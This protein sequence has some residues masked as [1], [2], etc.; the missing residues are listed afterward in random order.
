MRSGKEGHMDTP[1][2]ETRAKGTAITVE[3]LGPARYAEAAAMLGRAFDTDPLWQYLF[4]DP[5]KRPD[6]IAWLFERTMRVIAPL[7]ASYVT[8]GGEG[9]ALWVPPGHGPEIDLWA[10]LRAGFAW[11]PFHIGFE[12]LHRLWQVEMDILRRQR[13][14][15][16]E[17][18]WILS[19]I[20][21]DPAFRRQDVGS[22]LLNH[23]LTRIDQGHGACHVITHNPANVPFYEHYGFCVVKRDAIFEGGPFVCSLRRP[24]A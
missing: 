2:N 22:A 18:D 1:S 8:Q 13:A 24:A 14:E 5:T 4:P 7:G 17:P 15:V 9:A 23:V 11:T 3:P 16:R 10:G 21:V 20:G 6:Q 19:A 12:C